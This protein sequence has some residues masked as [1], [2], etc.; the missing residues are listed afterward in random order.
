MIDL[1]KSSCEACNK[2]TPK[3]S[4]DQAK[5]L[6]GQL[7]EWKLDE[8]N[9]LQKRWSFQNFMKPLKFVMAISEIA[10][11]ERHHPNINFG[12]GYVEVTIWTHAINGL[13]RNDFILAAKIDTLA[14]EAI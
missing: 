8:N 11:K 3:L 2:M 10:E 1:S 7:Q 5:E 4:L 9:H 12:W 6:L 13:S 14:V